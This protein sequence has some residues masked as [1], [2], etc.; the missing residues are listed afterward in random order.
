M[1]FN[2]CKGEVVIKGYVD[3]SY[4]GNLNNKRLNSDYT[5]TVY[6]NCISW[7]SQLEPIVALFSTETKYVTANEA[8][9]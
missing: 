7:K 3:S 9:K 6:D 1:V 5:Y 2:H 4:Y 8:A